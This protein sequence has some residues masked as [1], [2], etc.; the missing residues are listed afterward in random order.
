MHSSCRQHNV[1]QLIHS[2]I[3]KYHNVLMLGKSHS[4]SESQWQP[5]WEYEYIWGKQAFYLQSPQNNTGIGFHYAQESQLK[6]KR[7]CGARRKTRI[8]YVSRV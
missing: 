2:F 4:E 5:F 6:Y 7:P 1:V 3:T 8:H